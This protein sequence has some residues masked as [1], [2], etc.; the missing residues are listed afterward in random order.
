MRITSSCA[1][2]CRS[3]DVRLGR[4]RLPGLFHDLAAGVRRWKDG[5]AQLAASVDLRG[6]R[7]PT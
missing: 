7:M 4:T 1:L 5:S 2:R 6:D 3:L